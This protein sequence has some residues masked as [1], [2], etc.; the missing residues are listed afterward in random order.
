MIN[1]LSPI[2][3]LW[4]KI[5]VGLSFRLSCSISTNT[6]LLYYLVLILKKIDV[7]G[8]TIIF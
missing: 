6:S 4:R 5:D 1:N 7:T 3:N 2:N 8:F